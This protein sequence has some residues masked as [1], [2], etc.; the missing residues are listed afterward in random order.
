ML[1]KLSNP[2]Q[3]R[4]EKLLINVGDMSLKRRARKIIEET[5]P[6]EGEEIIDLGCGTGYYLYLLSNLLINLKL[7]GLEYDQRSL[8]EAK[9]ML[10]DKKINF[11]A[12][13]MHKMPFKSKSFDKA[14]SS[15]VLEHLKDDSLAL[16]EIYRILKPGGTLVISVPSTNYPFFWDPLNWVLQHFFQMHIKTGFFSGIWNGHIRLYNLGQLK[17]KFEKAGFKIEIAEELTYW[18]LPFNHYLVNVVARLLYD[19]KISPKIADNLSKFKVNKKP[20]IFDLAFKAV[21]LVD[22]L[23]EYFPKLHG[24]NIFIK[25]R[26]L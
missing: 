23:N 14:I 1:K 5:N 10:I 12:G 8:N 17:K 7:T 25:A 4:L 26:K 13:D 2:I 18:C 11:V 3:D 22:K 15:E 6:Q 9:A 21:N 16:Q 19:V 20:F 24:V